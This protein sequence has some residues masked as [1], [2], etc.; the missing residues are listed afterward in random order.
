MT[1]SLIAAFI[2]SYFI[3]SIPFGLILTKI[4]TKKDVRDIGSGN[5]GATN[6]TR[7]AGKKLGYITFI[8]DAAKGVIAIYSAMIIFG[9]SGNLLIYSCALL[10]IIGH[11]FPIWLKFKGGKGVASFIGILFCYNP[12]ITLFLLLGAYLVFYIT[13]II[14]VVSITLMAVI[15]IYFVF[16]WNLDYIPLIIAAILIII[17]HHDNIKRILAGNENSFK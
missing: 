7:A 1:L 6:V 17:K 2:T 15:I 13:R 9:L 12:I 14:A 8:L 5:I 11:M 10:A 3:G 4:F 16:E